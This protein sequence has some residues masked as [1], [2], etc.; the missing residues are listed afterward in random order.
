MKTKRMVEN[1][2]LWIMVLLFI[3]S[4]FC[5]MTAYAK[6]E[7]KSGTTYIVEDELKYYIPEGKTTGYYQI[8]TADDLNI[9]AK[10]VKKEKVTVVVRNKNGEAV[11]S[12]DDIP[13]H[14]AKVMNSIDATEAILNVIGTKEYPY[15]GEFSGDN[16]TITVSN[17]SDSALFGFVGTTGTVKNVRI[18][19]KGMVIANNEEAHYALLVNVNH[20]MIDQCVITGTMSKTSGLI[21]VAEIAG[22]VCENSGI[23]RNCVNNT[24]ILVSGE[25]FSNKKDFLFVAGVCARSVGGK[26]E[27]SSNTGN[28]TVIGGPNVRI[29]GIVA[30]VASGTVANCSNSG[31]INQSGTIANCRTAGIIAQITDLNQGVRG[32]SVSNCINTGAITGTLAVGGIIGNAAGISDAEDI[33]IT[34]CYNTGNVSSKGGYAGGI[35]MQAKYITIKKCTNIGNVN[36]KGVNTAGILGGSGTV[37]NVTIR[38]CYNHGVIKASGEASSNAIA[39]IVGQVCTSCIVSNCYNDG[40]VIGGHNVGGIVGL[41]AKSGD[42]VVVSDCYNCGQITATL[43]S[44]DNNAYCVGGIVGLWSSSAKNGTMERCYSTNATIYKGTILVEDEK[45]TSEND[46]SGYVIGM[47]VENMK[48]LKEIGAYSYSVENWENKINTLSTAYNV[49][50]NVVQCDNI[51]NSLYYSDNSAYIAWNGTNLVIKEKEELVQPTITVTPVLTSIPTPSAT[52][53]PVPTISPIPTVTVVPTITTMPGMTFVESTNEIILDEQGNK[54]TFLVQEVGTTNQLSIANLSLEENVVWEST[55]KN[56]VE[57]DKNGHVTMKHFGMAEIIVT[58]GEGENKRTETIVVIVE[59][60]SKIKND[61]TEAL[62]AIRLGTSW[63]DISLVRTLFLGERMDID[64]WGVKNWMREKYEYDWESSDESV[65]TTDEVGYIQAN[66]S[67]VAT[68][69]L[70][71][72]NKETGNFLNVK[73]MQVVIPENTEAPILLGTSSSCTFDSLVLRRNERV[74]LNFYGV[75]NWKAEAYD[76][77]W[78]SSE[79]T[80]VWVDNVG[81]VT[82]VQEGEA[83]V[84]LIMIEKETGNALYVMPVEVMVIE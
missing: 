41:V 54:V 44:G 50:E 2:M 22:I 28:I 9:L 43:A 31:A 77:Q 48:S 57:V 1:I 71:L 30:E 26:I 49:V 25:S 74:D 52:A 46:W 34:N 42:N 11:A 84:T 78:I 4:N 39:G 14:N 10:V 69:S 24:D 79:P 32:V 68:L 72:K 8:D 62:E 23:I 35:V 70:R 3:P 76:Y 82:P 75:E 81:N 60:E 18:E 58:I 53:T 27:N 29:S 15:N 36:S 16:Y 33:M 66:T 13:N 64:F 73:S 63:S 20:G 61:P 17:Y 5:L 40:T 45:G 7:A 6:E 67:G 51:L 65:M 38:D 47:P 83:I 80:I 56:V 55:N 21:G 19:T 12:I 37:G 59:E